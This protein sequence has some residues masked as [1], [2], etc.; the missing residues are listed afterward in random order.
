MRKIA[1]NGNEIGC[2]ELLFIKIN[3]Q[4]TVKLHQNKQKTR[5][6]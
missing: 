4:P 1:G 3:L 5:G 2:K 6:K